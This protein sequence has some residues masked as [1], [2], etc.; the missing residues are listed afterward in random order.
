MFT[1]HVNQ[2][3]VQS[4]LPLIYRGIMKKNH[5]WRVERNQRNKGNKILVLKEEVPVG[6]N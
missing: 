3:K 2:I 6:N 4:Q 5:E 1:T